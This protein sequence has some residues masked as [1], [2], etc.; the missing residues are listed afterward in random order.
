M[1][2]MIYDNKTAK[3]ISLGMDQYKPGADSVTVFRLAKR[4]A[5]AVESSAHRSVGM[6]AL[7]LNAL[8]SIQGLLV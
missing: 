3:Y 4:D 8:I 6:I 2:W 7:V 1:Y 5:K